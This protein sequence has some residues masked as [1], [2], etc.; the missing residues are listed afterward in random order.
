MAQPLYHDDLMSRRVYA[1]VIG[2][3]AAGMMCALRAAERCPD[4]RIVIIERADR[5]GKKL[6][7]TGN[8][9]CNLSHL[10]AVAESYHGEGSGELIHAL[11]EKYDSDAVLSYFNQL[12]LLTYADAEG[13]VYP[14][15]N[16]ASSVLDV[17]RLQLRRRG[18]EELCGIHITHIRNLKNGYE[19][20]TPDGAIVAEKLVVAVGGCTDYAGRANGSADVL[21]MLGLRASAA[22]PSLS[23]V[24]VK[25]DSLR[26]LK[27]IRAEAAVTLL[28]NG[29][30]IKEE[31]GEVQFTENALSGICVFNLSREANRGGC[32]L[33]LNLLPRL[34]ADEVRRE[35]LSR[36]RHGGS[37]PVSEIFVGMFHKNIAL[38]LLK[39]CGISPSISC[40]YISDKELNF[41]TGRITDCRFTCEKNDDFRK[42]QVT[43]GGVS[44]SAIDHRTFECQ[45]HPGLYVIGEALDVDGDCG[46]YNL[47]FAWASGMCAGDSL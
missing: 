35:I 7:V 21:R 27:G 12:G 25:G 8:G 26:P 18:V 42:A 20:I 3:G 22:S 28:K 37:A 11:F 1:A 31:T 33:S 6:L 16:L 40:D 13:R 43:A 47:Q 4:R 5:V 10:G 34:G 32:E 46:G 24:K 2:G 17:M 29:H 39:S 36:L 23:P 30:A 38:F 44:L 14:R 9:R 41:L 45:A 19:I 15:T